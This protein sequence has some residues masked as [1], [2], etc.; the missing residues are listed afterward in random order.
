MTFPPG[1][2]KSNIA[3]TPSVDLAPSGGSPLDGLPQNGGATSER[4]GVLMA[5]DVFAALL[6]VELGGAVCA[7]AAAAVSD[8][9][10]SNEARA[11][12]QEPIRPPRAKSAKTV[13]QYL[14]N[15]P[16]PVVTL[17]LQAPL[18]APAPD[19]QQL[20]VATPPRILMAGAQFSVNGGKPVP[21]TVASGILQPASS[22][23]ETARIS[24]AGETKPVPGNQP[25]QANLA[26]GQT[27][28][29]TFGPV[30]Q[31]ILPTT[32]AQGKSEAASKGE[33][34]LDRNTLS[35][36]ALY[37]ETQQS[38]PVFAARVVAYA[39]NNLGQERP[40]DR[41]QP[42]SQ[43]LPGSTILAANSAPQPSSGGPSA[44]T[45]DSHSAV[46]SQVA[47]AAVQVGN[48]I[49]ARTEELKINSRT[50]VHLTLDPPGLGSVRIHLTANEQTVS[51]RLVVQAESTKQLLESQAG[52]LRDRLT[53]SGVTLGRFSVACDG[54]GASN[55][56]Q[57]DNS[58][59][60]AEPIVPLNSGKAAAAAP[61]PIPGSQSLI[62]VIV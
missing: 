31:Q 12:S 30:A 33:K 3:P 55:H 41:P 19:G 21:L 20:T 57:Q 34:A 5:G 40:N 50:T 10:P 1:F 58:A 61:D 42:Q 62:D 51:A 25:D 14:A 7:T 27:K 46:P 60:Q 15:F 48:A 2:L 45:A 35:P 26:E 37:P 11:N 52:L 17:P 47:S 24:S 28:L 54:G 56:W 4:R 36:T 29:S 9:L 53:E 44:T 49:L 8:L 16:I 59:V 38:S 43:E 18:I 6:A 39:D 32:D 23:L 22:E 13:D